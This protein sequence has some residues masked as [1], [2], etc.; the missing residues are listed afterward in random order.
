MIED[1]CNADIM[2]KHYSANATG[3]REL[4]RDFK[5]EL[6]DSTFFVTEIES[7]GRLPKDSL[8]TDHQLKQLTKRLKKI[9]CIGIE[10]SNTG[11]TDYN[12]LRFKRIG[13]VMYS[14]RLYDHALTPS[15]RDSLNNDYQ[16]IVYDDSTVFEYG[17]GVFGPQDFI[18]KE[19]YMKKYVR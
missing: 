13:M 5:N 9:G 8:F 6:P 3:M 16:L 1:Q 2:E 12:T 18:G 15:Q 4:V 7:F 11:N 17:G 19:E 14:F 10:I